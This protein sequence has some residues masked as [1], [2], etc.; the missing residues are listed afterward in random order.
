MNV[1]KIVIAVLLVLLLVSCDS[2]S[3]TPDSILGYWYMPGGSSNWRSLDFK[4]YGEVEGTALGGRQFGTYN[5]TYSAPE[6]T[7]SNISPPPET[8]VGTAIISGDTL[9]LSGFGSHWFEDGDYYRQ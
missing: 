7:V 6:L 1:F 3:S 2:D 5:Y 9:T 4:D 8:T